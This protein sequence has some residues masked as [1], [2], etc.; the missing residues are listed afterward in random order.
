[1]TIFFLF[2]LATTLGCVSTLFWVPEHDLGRGY[3]QM[4]ALIV[5]GLLGLAVSVLALHPFQPF[6]P[7]AGAGTAAV[8]TALAG[9]FLYYAAVW[10]ERWRPARAAAAL[11]LAA[12][13]TA[14]LLTSPHLAMLAPALPHRGLLTGLDLVSSA[15]LLGWALITMLLGHWYLISPR[16]TFRYLVTFCWV[17]M[18]VIGA[19]LLIVGLG[20]ALAASADSEHWRLLTGFTGQGMFFWFRILWGLAIPLTLGVLSLHCARQRSNQSATGILYVVVVGAFIGELTAYYLIVT[21][22]VPV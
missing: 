7:D 17:L 18:A 6:G 5:L 12:S 11:V 22:G 20:L 10:R 21:T 13:G 15:L 4:N 14:L 8:A 3:F 2:L 16:L 1:M 19:R 9:A